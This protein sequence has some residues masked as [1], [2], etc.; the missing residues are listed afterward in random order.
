MEH[1]LAISPH[2]V[3]YMNDVYDM[4][5]KVYARPADDPMKYLNV[6]MVIWGMFMNATLRAAIHFG[7]DHDVN[8]RHAQNSS[9]RTTGQL[10]GDIEKLTS[11]STETPGI[12]LIDFKDSRWILTS[13]LHSRAHQHATAKVYVFSDSVLCLGRMGDDPD[14]SWNKIQRS[15]LNRIDG[16][17]MDFE[18]KILPWIQDSGY[19]QRDS[20]YD[21]RITV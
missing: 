14:K 6:N 5:R 2:H 9:W 1:F 13:L 8:L 18:W 17:P 4:V 16:T 3:P 19:P 10:F 20:E 12:N 11:G 7:N 15:E 21:G